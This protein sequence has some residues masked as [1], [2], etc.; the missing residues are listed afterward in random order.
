MNGRRKSPAAFCLSRRKEIQI[1][2][3]EIQAGWNKIQIRRNEIQIQI[4]RFPSPYR[5]F[6]MAY[7][8][9]RSI[10]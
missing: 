8:D 10:L 7:A 2:R 1:F 3:N 6:S 5:A 4:I 9:P